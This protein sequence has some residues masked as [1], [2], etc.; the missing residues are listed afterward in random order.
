MNEKLT[1]SSKKATW[2]NRN[3]A[4]MGFTSLF[5]DAG[6]EMVTAVLPFFLAV[7]GAGPE[8]LGLIEGFSDGASSFVK[9]FSGYLSDKIGKR[10]PIITIGY[11]L[12]GIFTPLIAAATS[13]F[14]VLGLRVTAWLGRGARGP[15]RDALLADSVQSESTGKAFGFHRTMD[16][17]GAIIGPALALFFLAFL[18][19]HQIIAVSVIPGLVAFFIVVFFVHEVRRKPSPNASIVSKRGDAVI[20]NKGFV[21]SIMTLPKSFKLFL[22]GVGVF[23]L[24]NFANSLFTLRAQEVLAPRLGALEASVIAVGLYTLLNVAYAASSFPIGALSDR[25]GRRRILAA[26]YFISAITCLGTAFLTADFLVLVPLFL[27]AGFFTAITDTIEGTAAADLL[28]T[29][30]RGTGFGVLQTVNGIGDFA[31]SAV[32]GAL[33]AIVSPLVAFTYA[34]VLSAAGGVILLYLTQ[35]NHSLK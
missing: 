33:W 18:N 6:H 26:G 2:L 17:L 4:A 19:Y 25:I 11:A 8:A 14:Q 24:G 13:W 12:T 27:L 28:P 5:S 29:E 16:T 30:S 9:S 20:E 22:I 23:G 3:V 10:K 31:S 21:K 35:G 34:A 32:V 15:P 7:I 1:S